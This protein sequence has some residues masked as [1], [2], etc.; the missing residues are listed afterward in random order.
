MCLPYNTLYIPIIVT[1][2]ITAYDVEYHVNGVFYHA[3]CRNMSCALC[4][5]I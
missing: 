4:E 1:T 2:G 5:A 3:H